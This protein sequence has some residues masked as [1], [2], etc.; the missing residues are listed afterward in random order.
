MEKNEKF[1]IKQLQYVEVAD[2]VL[3]K[4]SSHIPRTNIYHTSQVLCIFHLFVEVI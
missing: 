1:T 3:T 4:Q 2:V